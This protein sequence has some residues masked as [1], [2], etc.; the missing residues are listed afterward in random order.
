MTSFQGCKYY[1]QSNAMPFLTRLLKK[2]SILAFPISSKLLPQLPS[3]L[4]SRVSLQ[5]TKPY[6]GTPIHR[7]SFRDLPT[8]SVK[9]GDM[10]SFGG[11]SLF[12]RLSFSFFINEIPVHIRKK[13]GA[14]T[15]EGCQ[16]GKFT[17]GGRI[18]NLDIQVQTP[19]L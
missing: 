15:T 10:K 8:S 11:A 17:G 6:E 14:R 18:R 7:N 4:A 16:V 13:G 5:W 9:R 12:Y 19:R 3:W 2:I 1:F